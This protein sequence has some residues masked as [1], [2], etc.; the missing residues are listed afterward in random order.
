MDLLET[1][2]SPKLV[3]MNNYKSLYNQFLKSGDLYEVFPDATGEW[4]KDKK[5]FIELQD[6][7][8]YIVIS[9]DIIDEEEQEEGIY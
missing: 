3:Q 8:N 6:V 7:S 2:L 5:Q 9:E 1:K 4:I